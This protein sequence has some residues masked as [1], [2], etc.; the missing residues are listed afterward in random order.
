MRSADDCITCGEGTF[1]PVG[2]ED[3]TD[4]SAGTFNDRPGQETC[5]KC[6]GGTY[7]AE[8]GQTACVPCT[9]GHYCKEGAAAPLPC[10]EGTHANA[11]NLTSADQ[12][13]SA[14]PGFYATTGSTE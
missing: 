9:P 7:Q 5:T 6:V 10:A 4:C 14:E 2:S 11:T 3:A 8:A 13:T 1:C 12:C